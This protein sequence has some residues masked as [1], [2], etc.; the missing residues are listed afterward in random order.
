MQLEKC[1]HSELNENVIKISRKCGYIYSS[2]VSS[3]L[4]Q[5]KMTKNPKQKRMDS[6]IHCYAVD[7]DND[8][9]SGMKNVRG[10]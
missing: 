9:K 5:M 2:N 4:R 8:G 3:W 6:P 7:D 10:E 1:C